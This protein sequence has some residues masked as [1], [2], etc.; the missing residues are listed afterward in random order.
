MPNLNSLLP[1]WRKKA[2]EFSLIHEPD[3][4]QVSLQDDFLRIYRLVLDPYVAAKRC[5]VT[6]ARVLQWLQRYPSFYDEMSVVRDEMLAE[7]EASALSRA[8][9][10]T[11]PSDETKSGFVEDATGRVIRQGASDKMTEMMLKA[12]R[13]DR[14]D[15]NNGKSDEK[16][17]K[18][19][20]IIMSNGKQEKYG[21]VIEHED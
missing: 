10:Y 16:V 18:G 21:D 7:L 12:H 15:P 6:S 2:E 9:G 17:E 1:E 19:V 5:G 8:I 13:P 11:I 14:Y 3:M 4:E 20:V